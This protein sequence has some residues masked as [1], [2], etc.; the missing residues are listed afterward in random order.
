[1]SCPHE[2]EF[3]PSVNAAHIGIAT[4][5]DVI[6]L[7]AGVASF[8]RRLTVNNVEVWSYSHRPRFPSAARISRSRDV[9]KAASRCGLGESAPGV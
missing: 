2:L 4:K 5:N 9:P 8:E 3:G 7:T 6:T 1:M